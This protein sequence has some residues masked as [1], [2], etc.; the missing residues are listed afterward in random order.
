[1]LYP[2]LATTSK[3][4]SYI[5][6]I[7]KYTKEFGIRP[8]ENALIGF[9]ITFDTLLRVSQTENFEALSETITEYLTLKFNYKQYAYGN[10]YNVGIYI[11]YYGTHDSIK[12]VD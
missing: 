10:Y 7:N 11:L 9:D 4:I 2:S 8:P 5:K 12:E 3:T 6:F 1:M